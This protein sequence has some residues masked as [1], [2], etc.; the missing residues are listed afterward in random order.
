M[1]RYKQQEYNTDLPT[2]LAL[3]NYARYHDEATYKQRVIA[4]I[5]W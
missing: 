1:Y 2:S 4:I 3:Q 5:I